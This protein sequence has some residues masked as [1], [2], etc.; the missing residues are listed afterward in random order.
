MSGVNDAAAVTTASAVVTPT[1][2]ARPEL[3]GRSFGQRLARLRRE[4]RLSQTAL[5]GEEYSPSYISLLEADKRTPSDTVIATLARRLNCSPALLQTG[6]PSE[7]ERRL[8]LE[9][10]YSQLA[11]SHGEPR[12]AIERLRPLLAESD[13]DRVRADEATFTLA[14]AHDQ[15]GET[16]AVIATLAE[17]HDR[18][19]AAETHLLPSAVGSA[20]CRAYTISGDLYRSL[21]VGQRALEASVQRGLGGTDDYYTLAATLLW[22]YHEAGDVGHA[23]TWAH[24]LIQEV[25]EQSPPSFG[26]AA[27]YWNAALIAESSGRVDEALHLSRLA[28]ARMAEV[29]GSRNLAR[30]HTVVAVLL[31]KSNPP[32]P[33]EALAI[34]DSADGILSDLGGQLD[35]ALWENARAMALLLTGDLAGAR[36]ANDRALHRVPAE[37]HESWS[38]ILLT[39]FDIARADGE[40]DQAMSAYRQTREHLDLLVANRT[41]GRLWR[42]LGDRLRDVELLDD[43]ANCYER[44]LDALGMQDQSLAIRRAS[45]R[46]AG[47]LGGARRP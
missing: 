45:V 44:A 20:L 9:L 10:A 47:Q 30:L 8:D 11:L 31:V 29:G 1:V 24:T 42:D 43:A 12:V 22:A 4:A 15:L 13:L 38:R 17:L 37:D 28:L 6:H 5:A 27:I 35:R 32:R 2:T 33:A 34:L 14:R 3:G 40:L 36:F 25:D 16:A 23:S 21:D 26:Q 46:L 41:T 7:R 19:L 39:A 18:A